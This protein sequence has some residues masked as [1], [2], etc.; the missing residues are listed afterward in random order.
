MFRFHFTTFFLF[1]IKIVSNPVIANTALNPDT[2]LFSSA[3]SLGGAVEV[4]GEIGDII[5]VGDDESVEDIVGVW[6]AAVGVG[7]IVMVV[8]VCT[9]VAVG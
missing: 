5:M 6:I 9:G 7:V 8:V 2:P 3:F 1:N 4:V